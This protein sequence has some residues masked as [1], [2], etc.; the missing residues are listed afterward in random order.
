MQFIGLAVLSNEVNDILP[1][2]KLEASNFDLVIEH[3]E[4]DDIDIEVRDGLL[5]FIGSL[6]LSVIKIMN[7]SKSKRST[8]SSLVN[9]NLVN[10][11]LGEE[12]AD[13][14][15]FLSSTKSILPSKYH[16]IFA[17]EWHKGELCRYHQIRP[18]ALRQYF[19]DNNSW[20]VWLYDYSKG[21]YSAN[22]DVPLILEIVND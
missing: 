6:N 12:K 11:F 5:G 18:E 14:L 4:A 8:T 21:H 17:F 10:F 2:L 20:Y 16:L 9:Q 13:L 19:K 15:E 1:K 7:S 3:Q 22:L